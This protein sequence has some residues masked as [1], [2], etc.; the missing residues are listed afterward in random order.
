[1]KKNS[2]IAL[3]FCLLFCTATS[4]AQIQDDD[5]QRIVPM[6]DITRLGQGKGKN[7][8]PTDTLAAMT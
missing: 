2:S 5:K 1:M 4:V 6:G 7:L 3:L 8:E